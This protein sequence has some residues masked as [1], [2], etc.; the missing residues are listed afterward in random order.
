MNTLI[1]GFGQ[2]V[3]IQNQHVVGKMARRYDGPQ[4]KQVQGVNVNYYPKYKKYKLKNIL[5]I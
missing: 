1:S 4:T 5:K 2:R 3:L